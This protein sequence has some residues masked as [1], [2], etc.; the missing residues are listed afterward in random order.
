VINVVLKIEKVCYFTT[1]IFA[2]MS[3]ILWWREYYI[4]VCYSM[5]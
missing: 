5:V 2:K 4:T 1:N 3:V